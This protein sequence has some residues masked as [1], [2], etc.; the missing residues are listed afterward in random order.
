MACVPHDHKLQKFIPLFAKYY[1]VKIYALCMCL[2][3]VQNLKLK[4][5][6]TPG[7]IGIIHCWLL[8]Y[9]TASKIFWVPWIQ[10]FKH[11][12]STFC[13]W[14]FHILSWWI[15]YMKFLNFG[16]EVCGFGSWGLCILGMKS[17]HF[18]HEVYAFWAWSLCI[19]SMR[20]PDHLTTRILQLV[21][22]EHLW[23]DHTCLQQRAGNM[24]LQM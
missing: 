7:G 9:L 11:D 17:V 22:T 5:G 3:H 12:V 8:R 21:T 4:S 23:R 14:R 20:L 24:I 18:G 15:L 2:R 1:P 19:L 13:E 10:V 16:H 6:Y